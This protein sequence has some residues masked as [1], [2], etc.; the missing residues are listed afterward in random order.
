MQSCIR[1]AKI[2][3]NVLL[4]ASLLGKGLKDRFIVF[5]KKQGYFAN[6]STLTWNEIESNFINEMPHNICPAFKPEV[7]LIMII[8]IKEIKA[9]Q[10]C[11]QFPIVIFLL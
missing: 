8:E 7:P 6:L 11:L 5:H 4:I 1:I 9:P 2:V 10:M 3:A